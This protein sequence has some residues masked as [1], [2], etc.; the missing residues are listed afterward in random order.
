M[1]LTCPVCGEPWEFDSLHDETAYRSE[2][3]TPAPEPYSA[4]F[5]RVRAEFQRE[6]CEALKSFGASHGP[7]QQN[8]A[9]V[10]ALAYELMGDDLDGAASMLDDADFLGLM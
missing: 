10:A 8:R 6:G 7:I 1:D 9:D 3:I 4:T 2:A 5:D